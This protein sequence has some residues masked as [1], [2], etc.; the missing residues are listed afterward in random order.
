MTGFFKTLFLAGTLATT[1]T[2]S[3]LAQK[4]KK[5]I[6]LKDSLDGK[7]DLS[8]Y[9]IDANG[10]VPVP[11]II[12]EPALGGFG[13]A[14]I[15]V[16]I[17][18]NKP[19]IDS[20]KG[21]LVRTPV[22]PNVTGGI[23]AYTANNT[24]ILGGF[25]SGTFVKSR[26]KYTV[27]GAYAN[28]NMSFYRTFDRLGEKELKFNF[29][30]IPAM[31]QA[32]KR[33]GYSHWYAG[34]KYLFL[35]T[36]A[37]YEGDTSLS[38]L[39]KNMEFSSIISQLGAIIELDNRDNIF[40]PDRGKKLH[41]DANMSNGILGSDFDFW[42]IN[43]YTYMYWQLSHKLVGGL[44]VDGQQVF[45]DAPF[46]Q[47]PYVDM[48][49]VPVNRYQGKADILT[50]AEFRWDVVKRWSIMAFAGTGK[51]FDE[52]SE[53]GPADWVVSGGTGFR[54]LLAR[55]FKL[56]VGIDIARGPDT[57]AWYIVFG[58]NWLK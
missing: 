1:V 54:Y 48:R 42:R 43:Y 10:F 40:S 46:Y 20:V 30:T 29:K 14:L 13:G 2:T 28:V 6:S 32:T 56:R 25:R 21:K 51:A 36:D 19:Y 9:I 35:K 24:W 15:P 26:I 12:T 27:F 41:V 33:I 49:G 17:N 57:W 37:T 44:R 3:A 7:F 52:W 50:E 5:L 11:Y 16:F 38:N 47:L 39:V 22:A 55:K 4:Q 31:L 34:F 58:S 53:F 8:D 18:K 45:G 23:L